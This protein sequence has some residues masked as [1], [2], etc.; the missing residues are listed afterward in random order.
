MTPAE[1]KEM[2]DSNKP[3]QHEIVL[4]MKMDKTGWVLSIGATHS[5]GIFRHVDFLI[6]GDTIDV[7]LKNLASA[8]PGSAERSVTSSLSENRTRQRGLPTLH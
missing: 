8:E 5:D 7:L 2:L 3:S 4:L 6:E 1:V